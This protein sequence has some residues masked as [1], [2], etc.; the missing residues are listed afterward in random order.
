MLNFSI[1][2]RF[3]SV[4]VFGGFVKFYLNANSPLKKILS[5][6]INTDTKGALESVCIKRV[7]F[8]ENV[9]TLFPH[10]QSNL[11]ENKGVRKAGFDCIQI[12]M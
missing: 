5:N 8:K 11:S 1:N 3:Q 6:A 9:R 2:E 7:E 12:L 4:T 10:R